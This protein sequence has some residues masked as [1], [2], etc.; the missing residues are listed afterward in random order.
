MTYQGNRAHLAIKLLVSQLSNYFQ[1][2][3]NGGTEY[4]AIIPKQLMQYAWIKR[5]YSENRVTDTINMDPAVWN[6]AK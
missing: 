3:K 1:A 5:Q 2:C 6:P 4:L